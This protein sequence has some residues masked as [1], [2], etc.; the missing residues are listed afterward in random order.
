MGGLVPHVWSGSQAQ[1]TLF[2]SIDTLSPSICLC[3][4]HEKELN[5]CGDKTFL[6]LK[7]AFHRENG[8]PC[9]SELS[10]YLNR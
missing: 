7:E 3:T 8:I 10:T 2:M 9:V 6:L 1:V 4:R 5:S